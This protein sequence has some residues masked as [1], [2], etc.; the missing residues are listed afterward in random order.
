MFS[1][2]K[3]LSVLRKLLSFMEQYRHD[4]LTF[5]QDALALLSVVCIYSISLGFAKYYGV[6]VV[7]DKGI[8]AWDSAVLVFSAV[9]L[10]F[11]A[12]IYRRIVV[13]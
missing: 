7:L 3:T 10:G 5:V 2:M 9:Y 6:P 11:K 13:K 4:N 8:C 12:Q 1:M